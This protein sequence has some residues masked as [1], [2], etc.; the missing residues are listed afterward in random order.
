MNGIDGISFRETATG[1]EVRVRRSANGASKGRLKKRLPYSFKQVSKQILQAKTSDAARPLVTKLRSKLSWLYKKLRSGEYGEREVSAAILHA[2]AMERI[3]K[4]KV[5]HLEQEEA[6]EQGESVAVSQG[7]EQE[8]AGKDELQE[9]LAEKEEISEAR[10][11]EMMEEI[12]KLEEELAED[13]LSE[14]Q[15]MA[16]YSGR[17]LSEEEIADLK[18][19]H[20]SDEERQITRADLKYL[21]AQFER[22]EQEK[23]E[24]TA[25]LTASAGESVE[26]VFSVAVDCLPEVEMAEIGMGEGFDGRA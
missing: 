10:M 11:R 12:E 2:A 17:E 26:T 21:K 25:A 13:M 1:L 8:I 18:R 20:R 23:R 24:A 15:D 6:A 9:S 3:A 14:M 16:A 4:R 19:K 22:L 7:E 5:K